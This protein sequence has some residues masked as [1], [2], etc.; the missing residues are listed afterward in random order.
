MI[1]LKSLHACNMALLRLNCLLSPD[2]F[3]L[4]GQSFLVFMLQSLSFA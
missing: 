4:I 3:L 2:L 1:K